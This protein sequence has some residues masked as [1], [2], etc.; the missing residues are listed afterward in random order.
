[1][2]FQE[3]VKGDV[4]PVGAAVAE[5]SQAPLHLGLTPVAFTTIAPG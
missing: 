1:M 5:P 2:V 4:P 3:N